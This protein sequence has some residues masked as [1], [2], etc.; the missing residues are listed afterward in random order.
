[1]AKRLTTAL[2]VLALCLA[3]MPAQSFAVS[4]AKKAVIKEAPVSGEAAFNRDGLGLIKDKAGTRYLIDRD[5]GIFREGK[6]WMDFDANSKTY[7]V[8]GEGYY[9]YPNGETWSPPFFRRPG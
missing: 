7:V 2:L 3:L 6:A 8:D 4:A 9:G 5:G 1:M